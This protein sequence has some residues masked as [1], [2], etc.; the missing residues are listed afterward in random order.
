MSKRKRAVRETFE[1]KVE[2]IHGDDTKRIP[3]LALNTQ[4]DFKF[5]PGDEV[6][7]TVERIA[8]KRRVKR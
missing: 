6:L 7:V 3:W 4:L 2:W 8:P 5:K 1:A